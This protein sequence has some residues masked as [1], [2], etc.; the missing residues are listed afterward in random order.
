M[1]RAGAAEYFRARTG[2]PTNEAAVKAKRQHFAHIVCWVT[3]ADILKSRKQWRPY[4]VAVADDYGSVREMT[5]DQAQLP[6][7]HQLAVRQM[8]VR[9]GEIVARDNLADPFY[10]NAGLQG[11][12]MRDMC[13]LQG[14]PSRQPVQSAGQGVARVISADPAGEVVDCRRRL[15]HQ[16]KIRPF[17][18]GNMHHFV[19]R[20][21]DAMQQ[22]PADYLHE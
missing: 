22:V 16:E 20:R 7:V 12:L 21:A 1:V 10:E 17:A 2:Q 18:F 6:A 11:D 15:L 5:A 19:D 3:F 9:H 4:H 13:K 14:A 8:Y